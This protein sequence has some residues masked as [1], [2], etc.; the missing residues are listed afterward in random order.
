MAEQSNLNPD[1]EEFIPAHLAQ[2]PAPLDPRNNS[3]RL[4]EDN[5]HNRFKC[6]SSFE[7]LAFHLNETMDTG[8]PDKSR[9]IEWIDNCVNAR[10]NVITNRQN[11]E[12]DVDEG[13]IKVVKMLVNLRTY[14]LYNIQ[15]NERATFGFLNNRQRFLVQGHSGKSATIVSD[16]VYF[17]QLIW[18]WPPKKRYGGK[19][20]TRKNR[21]TNRKTY[22]ILPRV[23]GS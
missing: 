5:L 7:S 12:L 21:K 22:R 8:S 6:A 14:I 11:K 19:K 20:S 16:G 13:H 17:N 23:E 1:V 4:P 10:L 3:D 9:A 15:D 18:K 2:V